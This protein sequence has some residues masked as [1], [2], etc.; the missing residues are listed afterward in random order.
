MSFCLAV[1]ACVAIVERGSDQRLVGVED[2][3]GGS[4]LADL[5]GEAAVDG[6]AQQYVAQARTRCGRAEVERLN[7]HL[8]K[9]SA[10]CDVAGLQ[11]AV[12]LGNDGL[13]KGTRIARR[14]A[15]VD[16]H[17][18]AVAVGQREQVAAAQLV[19]IGRAIA[20]GPLVGGGHQRLED[21]ERR[22]QRGLAGEHL[23]ALRLN[24]AAGWRWSAPG[25]RRC[26]AA[27]VSAGCCGR[28]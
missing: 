7:G 1:S 13:G 17:G 11:G 3:F 19:K 14:A 27:P 5:L 10:Y 18:L 21:G 28:W 20:D 24:V 4:G 8:K 6:V 2:D 23:L 15:V 9:V 16:G 26:R 22:Q 12:D 25:R